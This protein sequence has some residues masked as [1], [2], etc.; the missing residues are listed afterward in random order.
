MRQQWRADGSW[1]RRTARGVLRAA[2][3]KAA[4]EG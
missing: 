1:S 4:L 3:Q 2:A